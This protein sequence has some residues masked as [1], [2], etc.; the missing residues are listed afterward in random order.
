YVVFIAILS[1]LMIP[2]EMLVL[3]WYS[4][5]KTFGWLDTYWGIAVSG[6]ITGFGVFLMKNFFESVPDELLDAARL[7]GLNEF[8]VWWQGAMPLVT[9]P[10][11][12]PAIFTFLGNW[13]AFLWPL[14]VITNRDL[15]TLPVGLASFSGEFQTEWEM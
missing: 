11:A 4:M 6:L 13:R 9:P 5:A 14:I 7:D 1:T 3:P 8:Q 12:G 15:Y 2:T 10:L